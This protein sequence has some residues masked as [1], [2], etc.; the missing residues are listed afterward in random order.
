MMGMISTLPR[1][2]SIPR[3]CKQLTIHEFLRSDIPL[4]Q[5]NLVPH[6]NDRNLLPNNQQTIHSRLVRTHVDSQ[7]ADSRQPVSLNPIERARVVDRICRVPNL[8][9][10]RIRTQGR[11]THTRSLRHELS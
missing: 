5:I 4:P 1:Q 3:P 8:S 6:E 10:E 7:R 11:R 2:H 9:A